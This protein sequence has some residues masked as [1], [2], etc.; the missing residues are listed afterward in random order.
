MLN[1]AINLHENIQLLKN[2]NFFD[3]NC[4]LTIIY[5]GFLFRQSP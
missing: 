4:P 3:N 5:G 1:I 2:G